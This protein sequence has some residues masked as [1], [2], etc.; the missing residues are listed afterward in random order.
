MQIDL[1]VNKVGTSQNGVNLSLKDS[2]ERSK[3]QICFE[4][5]FLQKTLEPAL[6]S[7]KDPSV[8]NIKPSEG[9]YISASD[10]HISL[11]GYSIFHQTFSIQYLQR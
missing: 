3:S 7:N 6:P 9:S 5:K 11:E 10:G 8:R 2:G 4:I 1:P